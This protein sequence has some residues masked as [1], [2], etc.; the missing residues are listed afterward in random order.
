MDVLYFF[1]SWILFGLYVVIGLTLMSIP[2]LMGLTI[3]QCFTLTKSGNIKVAHYKSLESEYTETISQNADDYKAY[4][5]RGEARTA[6]G[7]KVGALADY[8]QS[9]RIAPNKIDAYYNRAILFLSLFCFFEWILDILVI[10]RV[11]F[12]IF[13]VEIFKIFFI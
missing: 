11:V 8:T 4:F 9:L 7:D 1:I 10:V 3:F 2:I 12:L 6:L 5:K 13:F